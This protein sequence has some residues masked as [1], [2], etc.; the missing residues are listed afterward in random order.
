ME[1]GNNL[2]CIGEVAPK[3]HKIFL[4]SDRETEDF[5]IAEHFDTDARMMNRPHNRVRQSMLQSNSLPKFN[6]T[7]SSSSK[8]YK[9][10]EARAD[11]SSK[12]KAA[13]LNLDTQRNLMKGGTKKKLQANSTNKTNNFKWSRI[14]CK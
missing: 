14:R 2:H 12:L 4:S 9:D 11:Q 13:V 10:F 8:L 6:T 5:D 1:L 3:S 7:T